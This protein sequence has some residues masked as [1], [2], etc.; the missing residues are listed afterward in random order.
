MG[1]FTFYLIRT[2]A[3]NSYQH[4]KQEIIDDYIYTRIVTIVVVM[5]IKG[6]FY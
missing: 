6:H 5:L 3:Y 4:F 2:S 1:S